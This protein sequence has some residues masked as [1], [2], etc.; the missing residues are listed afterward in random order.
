MVALNPTRIPSS[1]VS[2]APTSF[3]VQ[4]HIKGMQQRVTVH[5]YGA[6]LIVSHLSESYF[7]FF[8]HLVGSNKDVGMQP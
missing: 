6:D 3:I 8:Y 1:V 2:L 5:A 4:R 7:L